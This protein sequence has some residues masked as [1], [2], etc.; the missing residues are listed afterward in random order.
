M[1]RLENKQKPPLEQEVHKVAERNKVRNY[2][3]Q[4]K[5]AEETKG[6]NFVSDMPYH[7]RQSTGKALK[8]VE[9]SLPYSLRKIK[10]L[11]KKVA[12]EAGL[13]VKGRN[14]TGKRMGLKEEQIRLVTEFYAKDG[15]SWQALGR[16]DCVIVQQVTN[17]ETI[18][19]TL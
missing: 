15:I 14:C 13:Q 19:K 1:K 2:Q 5:K 3:I 7:L 4:K 9:Q 6:V 12:T 18:K 16:K 10:F 11:L 8:K 17:G